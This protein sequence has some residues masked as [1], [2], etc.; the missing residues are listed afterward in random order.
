MY[1]FPPEIITFVQNL[2][3]SITSKQ[4]PNRTRDWPAYTNYVDTALSFE[5]AGHRYFGGNLV[6]L[7]QLKK[8]FDPHHR[9]GGGIGV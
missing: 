6:K 1:P 3:E 5:E 2:A 8:Q 7:K 9:L 4:S